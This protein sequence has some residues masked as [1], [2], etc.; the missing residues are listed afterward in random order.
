M[1]IPQHE[2]FV[3]HLRVAFEFDERLQQI[4]HLLKYD[5]RRI[6]ARELG[7]LLANEALVKEELAS[8]DFIVP[9]PLHP[10]KLRERGYNQSQ[11][12][13]QEFA[14]VVGIPVGKN[15]VKRQRYTQTQ[16]Q[17]SAEERKVNVDGAFRVM[18]KDKVKGKSILLVDDVLTTGATLNACARE[19]VL[20]GAREVRGLAIAHP[21]IEG[22]KETN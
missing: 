1:D 6:V 16:T 22:S 21:P 13:A 10:R 11:L 19:L 4:I 3:S 20:N 5:R 9:I 8:V 12:V 17:L 14:R 15:L 7:R 2:R 18:L